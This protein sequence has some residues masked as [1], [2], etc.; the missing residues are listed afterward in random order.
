MCRC[1]HQP[2]VAHAAP[3]AA[4]RSP[5][6]SSLPGPLPTTPPTSLRCRSPTSRTARA[7][8][9][10]YLRSCSPGTGWPPH[11]HRSIQSVAPWWALRPAIRNSVSSPT[12]ASCTCRNPTRLETPDGNGMRRSVFSFVF[13]EEALFCDRFGDLAS[14]VLWP[15]LDQ[16]LH[17]RLLPIDAQALDPEQRCSDHHLVDACLHFCR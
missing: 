17:A 12:L 1:P 11:R 13:V 8:R 4:L 5:E 15:A 7:T 16:A 10:R 3:S 2:E 14:E 9:W 6:R